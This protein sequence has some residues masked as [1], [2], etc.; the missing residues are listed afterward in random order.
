[1]TLCSVLYNIIIVFYTHYVHCAGTMVAV[2]AT[3]D[4]FYLLLLLLSCPTFLLPARHSP[5][6]KV[7]AFNP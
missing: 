3:T 7:G 6:R 5:F 2:L 4:V 1:M